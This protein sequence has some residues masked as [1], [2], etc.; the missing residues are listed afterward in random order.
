MENTQPARE[1]NEE[2]KGSGREIAMWC[3]LSAFSGVIIPFGNFLLPLVIWLAKR[4]DYPFVD[5]QGKE[6]LNFQ[7]TIFLYSI[8]GTL[9][10]FLVIGIFLLAV[11]MLFAVIQVIRGGIAASRGERF[12]YPL[13]IRILA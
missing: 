11:L 7:I 5:D 4:E 2:I 10:I 3:H 13:S 6:A 1:A 8:M 9:L 12:R